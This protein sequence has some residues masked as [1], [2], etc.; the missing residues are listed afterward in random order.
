M[1]CSFIMSDKP[2]VPQLPACT[3]NQIH[4]A[5]HTDVE[6]VGSRGVFWLSIHRR[7]V[8]SNHSFR[9]QSQ[10]DKNKKINKSDCGGGP[11]WFRSGW[12]GLCFQLVSCFW[13]P[14]CSKP[15]FPQEKLCPLQTN[16]L[17]CI[18]SLNDP[19]FVSSPDQ[20]I[21]GKKIKCDTLRSL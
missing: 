19:V 7:T 1:V 14:A 8:T 18:F 21:T 6:A 10:S 13:E 15:Q 9:M 2:N 20:M 12:P 4:P 11:V 16:S 3:V 17:H 5:V